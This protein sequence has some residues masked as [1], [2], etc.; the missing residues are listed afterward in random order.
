MQRGGQHARQH[1]ELRRRTALVRH[2]PLVILGAIL[3]VVVGAVV[4]SAVRVGGAPAGPPTPTTR[5]IAFD[6]MNRTVLS[7]FGDA[8]LGGTYQVS[9]PAQT[10]ISDG[11]GHV[12]SLRPGQAVSATLRSVAAADLALQ[13]T[14]VVPNLPKSGN[15][16]YT[17]LAARQQPSQ[18]AYHARVRITPTGA[19]YL[20]FSQQRGGHEYILGPETR[21]T[22]KVAPRQDLT[23]QLNVTGAN[24]VALR[25]RAWLAGSKLPSWQ[26]AYD[27]AAATRLT[28]AGAIG[29]WLY[30]SRATS[31]PMTAY[32]DDLAAY[33]V[34]GTPP[35]VPPSSAPNPPF[36]TKP[37][38]PPTSTAPPSTPAPTISAPPPPPAPPSPAAG[39]LPV[40][41]AAYAV[42]DDAVYVSPS[43]N[44]GADGTASAALRTLQHAVAVAPSGSTI[45]L[46][47]GIYHEQVEIPANKSLTVQ[48]F[49]HEAVWLD[50]S[51]AVGGWT[52][53][54]S[55]WVH[56]GWTAQF[57]STASYTAGSTANQGFINPAY[58][59]AAHPD[60][61]WIDGVAL[62]QVGSAA[63]VTA[64][65]FYADY[66]GKRLIV[67]SDPSG[68]DVRASDVE[69]ALT[70]RSANTTIRGLGVR[71][72]ASSVPDMATVRL[73]GAN[74]RL[75]NV[76]VTD[77]ATQGIT[78]LATHITVSHVTTSDNGLL[79]M[80]ANYADGLVVDHVLAQHNNL[81]HFN[82]APVSG[83][84]KFSRTRGITV[85]D[86][87]SR[88]NIGVGLWLD[89]SCY[90]ATVVRNDLV[91]NQG[92]GLS[93]EISATGV[94]ADNIVTGNGQDGFKINNANHVQIWNN[95]FGGNGRDLELVQDV[96][97][98]SDLSVPGHDPRQKLP[99]VTMT[100]ILSDID[101]FNNAFGLQNPGEYEIY[102]RDYTAQ[103]A[104]QRLDIAVD[105]SVFTKPVA[106]TQGEIVWGSTPGNV[107]IYRSIATFNAAT[108]WTNLEAAVGQTLPSGTLTQ[109]ARPLS[110]LIAAAIGQPAGSRHIG[111]F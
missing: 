97:H 109:L 35:V 74:D 71:R 57:D 5:S 111:A 17:A 1:A 7:G 20:S 62:R 104:P 52:K 46:R 12:T 60:R 3:P 2:R 73:I 16:L 81:E 15:G 29:V 75:E 43:G 49:P 11:V 78:A 105:N 91:N 63:A 59:M 85:T 4:L 42:P 50:G 33:R 28:G 41:S 67:G 76:V 44:D 8:Q 31:T 53:Q 40:G 47:G 56:A 37:A 18:D 102:A 83:G 88:D 87:V 34:D 22:G 86:T 9:A 24:P 61:A 95:T 6:A 39:S 90:N 21:T 45:V 13:A 89:E 80:H 84:L 99:D 77:N 110:A 64:G 36:T 38:P 103:S 94:L 92:H 93:F 66:A 54:G 82:F 14:F 69:L 27:D 72:Y 65:T 101:V 107:T 70:S 23:L 32:V 19:L 98:A 55:A 106:G 51:S 48:A 96:R 108:G 30:A 10:S 100:W 68:H 79:G 25:A 26:A 58:P